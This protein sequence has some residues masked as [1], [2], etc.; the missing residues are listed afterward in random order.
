METAKIFISVEIF[1]NL[2]TFSSSYEKNDGTQNSLKPPLSLN[3][4]NILRQTPPCYQ[5]Y[6]FQHLPSSAFDLNGKNPDIHILATP[7]S[8]I[9][10]CLR[11]VS[12]TTKSVI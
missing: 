6:S 12:K 8:D 7:D 3:I 10:P 5:T 1:T 11:H 2:F 9:Q 4:S